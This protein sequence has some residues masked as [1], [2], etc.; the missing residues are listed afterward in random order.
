MAEL[1]EWAKEI[2]QPKL[3][4]VTARN[5]EGISRHQ[6]REFNKNLWRLR[7][8]EVFEEVKGGSQS[9]EITNESRGWHVHAHL[10]VDARW[11]DTQQLAIAWGKLVGQEYAIVD[12]R[13]KRGEDGGAQAAK[14]VCKPAEFAKWR[15][16]EIAEFVH[17]VSQVRLF[18]VFGD[19]IDK[20]RKIRARLRLNRPENLCDCGCGQFRFRPQWRAGAVENYE[21]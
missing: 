20:R 3:V 17:A 14:Y 2:K 12:V 18:N 16:N 11:V 7:R 4:T 10:L 21:A 15:P 6:I 1:R 13:D 8:Q 9:I 19:F 5:T